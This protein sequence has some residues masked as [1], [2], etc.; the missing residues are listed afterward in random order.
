MKLKGEQVSGREYED[1]KDGDDD[2]DN[3]FLRVIT[4]YNHSLERNILFESKRSE[5]DKDG[6]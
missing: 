1:K 3:I 4:R 5:K 2:K 6:E